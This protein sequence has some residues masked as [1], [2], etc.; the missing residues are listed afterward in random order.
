MINRKKSKILKR[1]IAFGLIVLMAILSS[2]TQK[3]DNGRQA[4]PTVPAAIVNI[5]AKT[6]E[7]IK[8]EDKNNQENTHIVTEESTPKAVSDSQITQEVYEASISIQ[9]DEGFFILENT[10]TTYEKGDSVLSILIREGKENAFS[11]VFSG[12]K[13]NAYIEGIDNLFEFD[14]GPES[15]WAYK[16]NGVIPMKSSGAYEVQPKDEIQWIYV[17]KL[18]EA[19]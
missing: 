18:E 7:A 6:P 2:C 17:T 19:M 14:K 11:V 1:Y 10:K 16:V 9:T 13:R 15:G 3:Q 12:I 8:L 4:E 5:D